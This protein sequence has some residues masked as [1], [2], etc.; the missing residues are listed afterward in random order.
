MRRKRDRIGV[1]RSSQVAKI[2]GMSSRTLYRM[3]ADG[4]IPE[5]MRN[6]ENQYRVW[7]EVDLQSI[8]EALQR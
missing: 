7:T 4:R 8:R 1:Y 6:P 2:L 3:L 5:P